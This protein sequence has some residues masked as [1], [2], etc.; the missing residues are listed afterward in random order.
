MPP[1]F[2]GLPKATPYGGG[3]LLFAVTRSAG[4]FSTIRRASGTH[5]I[6]FRSRTS[7]PLAQREDWTV[8]TRNPKSLYRLTGEYLSRCADRQNPGTSIQPPPRTT[9]FEA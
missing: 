4:R 1:P 2:G 8:R 6:D 3:S 9:R 7:L 5:R